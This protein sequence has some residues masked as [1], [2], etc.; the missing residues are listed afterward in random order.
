MGAQALYEVGGYQGCDKVNCNEFGSNN[1]SSLFFTTFAFPDQI[2]QFR[3]YYRDTFNPDKK[4]NGEYGYDRP[5]PH[6]V[7]LYDAVD[8][9]L[10]AVRRAEDGH[11][12]IPSPEMIRQ[13]L[14]KPSFYSDGVTGRTTFNQ[15][16]N[17]SSDPG[18]KRLYVVCTNLAGH[19]QNLF[20]Y[21]PGEPPKPQKSLEDC[22]SST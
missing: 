20:E 7:L 13:A 17:A 21:N 1:Y 5:G 16:S 8:A 3:K 10:E 6:S 18:N 12:A 9:Y 19:T 11:T 15:D 14:K 22:N 2:P 4:H